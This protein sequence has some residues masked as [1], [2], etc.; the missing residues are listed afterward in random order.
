[1]CVSPFVLYYALR[2]KCGHTPHRD[3][4]ILLARGELR[5]RDSKSGRVRGW[6]RSKKGYKVERGRCVII[7]GCGIRRSHLVREGEVPEQR[8]VLRGHDLFPAGR[9]GARLFNLCLVS[10]R[11]F[12]VSNNFN[13]GR[14]IASPEEVITIGSLDRRVLSLID[15][16]IF[17]IKL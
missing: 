12:C 4:E 17:F 2:Y 10:N 13:S 9:E 15:L 11:S 1:M 16:L 14:L 7:E 8:L 6:V 3:R 5:P